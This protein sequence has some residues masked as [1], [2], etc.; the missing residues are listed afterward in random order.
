VL[1]PAVSPAANG[2]LGRVDSNVRHESRS[3]TALQPYSSPCDYDPPG[4]GTLLHRRHGSET[5]VPN[6]SSGGVKRACTTT[7]TCEVGR[8]GLLEMK[9][10]LNV[11]PVYGCQINT[12][13]AVLTGILHDPGHLHPFCLAPSPQGEL[14]IGRAS[15]DQ[16]LRRPGFVRRYGEPG[17]VNE[18]SG[19]SGA[20]ALLQP[21]GLS[22]RSNELLATDP[23]TN[24]VHRCTFT[25]NGA[26][27]E[28]SA[29]TSAL[30]NCA[31]RAVVA[32]SD[33]SEIVISPWGELPVNNALE[34]SVIRF[35]FDASRQ[36][37]DHGAIPL[38]TIGGQMLF[39]STGGQATFNPVEL[40]IFPAPAKIPIVSSG[41]SIPGCSATSNTPATFSSGTASPAPSRRRVRWKTGPAPGRRLRRFFPRPC[42]T[43]SSGSSK[44]SNNL[45]P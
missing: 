7:H 25:A 13:A 16:N 24:R 17:T 42:R 15:N 12:Q 21:H 43:A 32:K 18:F 31:A 3:L 5:D 14:F 37:V 40:D 28:Q 23:V 2:R 10:E 1:Y 20:G 19:Q 9:N 29:V 35:T 22:F 45:D 44:C 36:P 33:G 26:E 38:P 4:D 6:R 11:G 34:A 30:L 39:T 27:V 8:D 41:R